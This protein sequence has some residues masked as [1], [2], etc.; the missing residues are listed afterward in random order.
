[1]SPNRLLPL[2][3]VLLVA[4]GCGGSGPGRGESGP[5]CTPRGTT[6]HLLARS[7]RFNVDCLAAPAGA[8]FT[9]NLDNQDAGIPHSFG[10]YD[11]DPSVDPSATEIFRGGAVTGTNMRT[12]DVGPLDRGSFHFQCD[13]HPDRMR[14]S[15]LVGG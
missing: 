3:L 1:M 15:F 12:Y 2:A 9:V 8:R 6:L 4:G 5:S 7:T 14:G 13:V 10:I 11:G